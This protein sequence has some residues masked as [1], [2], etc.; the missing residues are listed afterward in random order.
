MKNIPP[1]IIC[2]YILIPYLWTLQIRQIKMSVSVKK[3]TQPQ[4]ICSPENLAKA[5]GLSQKKKRIIS[6][7]YVIKRYS[8]LI[9]L[10]QTQTVRAN[11]ARKHEH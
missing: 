9:T 10:P 8:E 2:K 7:E 11:G 4:Q 3:K 5:N 6:G 1:G